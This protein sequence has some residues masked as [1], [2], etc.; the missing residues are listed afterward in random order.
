MRQAYLFLALLVIGSFINSCKKDNNPTDSGYITSISGKFENWNS[1]SDKIIKFEGPAAAYFL[2]GSSSIDSL[3]RFN[4]ASLATPPANLLHSIDE[5]LGNTS[6]A[7]DYSAKTYSAAE[8]LIYAGTNSTP[9]GF[10][11]YLNNSS[12]NLDSIGAI[13]GWYIYTDKDVSVSGIISHTDSNNFTL[14]QENS[15]ILKSG[16]NK[17]FSKLT[18]RTSNAITYKISNLQP[19]DIKWYYRL[20]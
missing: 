20:F 10:T 13:T 14:T 6:L 12:F 16:W 19:S 9:L 15:I 18:L 2:F 1:G 17:C 11:S 7:T 5:M 4:I 8:L 3:G